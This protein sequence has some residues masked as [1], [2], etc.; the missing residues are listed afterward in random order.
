MSKPIIGNLKYK[1]KKKM[2]FQTYNGGFKTII[3]GLQYEQTYNISF[4][5]AEIGHL[6][7]Q[8]KKKTNFKLIVVFLKCCNSS[9]YCSSFLKHC[10]RVSIITV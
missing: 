5:T 9:T 3:I 4:K 7:Y 2:E 8:K 10:N 6:K 1:K